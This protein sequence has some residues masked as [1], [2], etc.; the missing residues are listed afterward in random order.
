[1]VM[2]TLADFALDKFGGDSMAEF[3]D[4]VER[5]RTRIAAPRGDASVAPVEGSD[6]AG[7]GGDD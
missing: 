2:L 1:M 4:N 5:Y 7:S 3:A 6:V